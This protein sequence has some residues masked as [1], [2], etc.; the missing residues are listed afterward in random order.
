LIVS[1]DPLNVNK[2]NC[3]IKCNKLG[4]KTLKLHFEN[5]VEKSIKVGWRDKPLSLKSV[6]KTVKEISFNVTNL[7]TVTKIF[8][9]A[10]TGTIYHNAGNLF[11]NNIPINKKTLLSFYIKTN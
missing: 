3:W 1:S 10:Q 4:G 9:E 5:T 11:D 8:R 6:Y 2:N 7:F